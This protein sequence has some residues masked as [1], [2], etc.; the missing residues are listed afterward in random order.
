MLTVIYGLQFYFSWDLQWFS[1]RA[2]LTM[3]ITIFLGNS[4]FTN[5]FN[6]STHRRILCSQ[7]SSTLHL[8]LPHTSL[9][10]TPFKQILQT[11]LSSQSTQNASSTC[12]VF[13]TLQHLVQ[14][15]KTLS[16]LPGCFHRQ[17]N[18]TRKKVD[19]MLQDPSQ[20]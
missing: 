9:P 10:P 6:I 12:S 3:L 16:A 8:G 5:P 7:Q 17:I 20:N 19:V 4:L 2:L 13:C 11:I 14:F 1:D 15:F 18:T